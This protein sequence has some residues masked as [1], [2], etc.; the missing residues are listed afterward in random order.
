[1]IFSE[2]EPLSDAILVGYGVSDAAYFD[3]VTGKA[4][5][6][7]LLP[8][9]QPRDMVTVENQK[10]DVPRDMIAYTDSEGNT[11]DFAFGMNWRGVI[12]DSRTA[13]YKVPAIIK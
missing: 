9:Q 3:I 1:M 6:S 10:E 13:K 4:E 11:Y 5:P 12:S 7:G 8:M 2:I